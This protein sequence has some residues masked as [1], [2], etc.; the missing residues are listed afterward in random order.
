MRDSDGAALMDT[1]DVSEA[2]AATESGAAALD[3]SRLKKQYRA[4]EGVTERTELAAQF[5]DIIDEK[6]GLVERVAPNLKV[7]YALDH[8]TNTLV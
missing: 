7:V 4:T 1:D 3:F 6:K 8:V 5:E 2:G